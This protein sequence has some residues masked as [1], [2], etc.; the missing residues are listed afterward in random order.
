M[1]LVIVRES[2]A[3]FCARRNVRGGS[4]EFMSDADVA[5]SFRAITARG[6]PRSA[7]NAFGFV[8]SRR[9]TVAAWD[10]NRSPRVRGPGADRRLVLR[11]AREFASAELCKRIANAAAATR[12]ASRCARREH[13]DEGGRRI[14][15]VRGD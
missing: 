7:H 1:D 3:N 2:I 11:R 4:G 5:H 9:A 14:P 8:P 6:S 12:A 15:L 13:Y 10:R